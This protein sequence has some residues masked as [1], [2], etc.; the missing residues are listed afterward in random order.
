[1]TN[2]SERFHF[3]SKK[4]SEVAKITSFFI[5]SIFPEHR[6][7]NVGQNVHMKWNYVVHLIRSFKVQLKNHS[8]LPPIS[9][10]SWEGGDPKKPKQGKFKTNQV[11]FS[12]FKPTFPRNHHHYC[13]SWQSLATKQNR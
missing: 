2:K 8:S 6:N 5:G 1:M 9:W 12:F 11:M 10:G 7:W 4:F 3:Q 13:L